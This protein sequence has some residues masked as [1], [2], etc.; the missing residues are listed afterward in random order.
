MWFAKRKK[1]PTTRSKGETKDNNEGE[2]RNK[3]TEN[4][5][6]RIETKAGGDKKQDGIEL[7]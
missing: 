2:L 5:K 7:E 4:V 6:I 1:W 3:E